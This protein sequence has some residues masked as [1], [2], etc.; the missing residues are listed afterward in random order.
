MRNPKSLNLVE[1]LLILAVIII[2]GNVGCSRR[3]AR[4]SRGAAGEASQIAAK[5]APQQKGQPEKTDET[6]KQT[7][8]QKGQPEKTDETADWITYVGSV[9]RFSLRYPKYWAV[10]HA[11]P[12]NCTEA[13]RSDF[14]AGANADL[15]ADCGTEYIGQIYIYS[16]EGNELSSHKLTTS[17]YPYQNITSKKVTVD[18]IEGAREAGTAMGQGDE[19]FAMPGLPDGTKVVV[20]SFY[21]HG[22][23]YVAEYDHRIGEPDI[24]R[25]FDLMIT[26]TL[27]FSN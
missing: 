27:K 25:D 21:V 17:Y 2:I 26:K 4:K 10:G 7:S 3:E 13:E 18:N 24:L 6:A 22:R 5:Q 16:N 8:Q 23:T 15:V 11:N 9:S 12:Q 19:K 14:T 20:Y 1:A